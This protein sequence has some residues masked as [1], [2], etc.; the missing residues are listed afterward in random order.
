MRRLPVAAF[1]ALAVVTVAAF[2]VT[3]HLKVTT[4][5]IAGYPAPE[6]AAINPVDPH[7]CLIRTPKGRFKRISFGSMLVSFYLLNRSDDVDVYIVASD[8][9]R[10]V[11]T[12]ALDRYMRG[13]TKHPVR[14]SFRWNGRRAD[15]SVAPDGTYYIRVSLIHQ[16]RSV[17]I[18]NLSG[19]AEPVTVETVAPRPQVTSVAPNVIS[20]GQT[21]TTI[22]FTGNRGLPTRILIYRT[23]AP[24]RPRLVK[25]YGAQDREGRA[26]WNGMIHGGPA[27]P[28][29]YLI[30]LEVTDRACNTGF[31]PVRMPPAP[32]TSAQAEVS[33]R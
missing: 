3:Q 26:V 17:L 15:G 28:G 10:V 27:A 25:S 5:L 12:L 33:V 31:F 9:T 19:A 8:G 14:T 29:T 1:V 32:G 6:P 24:G 20:S 13:G 21:D 18:S 11:R 30:G 2:F 4:P 16:E 23:G 22:R 7:K